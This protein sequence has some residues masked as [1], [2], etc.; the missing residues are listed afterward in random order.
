MLGPVTETP[1]RVCR[2]L[3]AFAQCDPLGRQAFGGGSATPTST[4][5]RRERA[6]AP[7]LKPLEAPGAGVG[8]PR[9]PSPRRA[10]LRDS[11]RAL[12]AFPQ[13]RQQYPASSRF[14]SSYAE[15]TMP[16]GCDEGIRRAPSQAW[17]ASRRPPH[18]RTPRA[19]TCPSGP[20]PETGD[21]RRKLG[22]PAGRRQAPKLVAHVAP[23]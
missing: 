5:P 7:R 23:L 13:L 1:S 4:L 17:V 22:Q 21:A 10:S 3:G 12:T 14:T 11:L 2:T 18:D 9:R 19:P 8:P 16:A 20:R 6:P 15:M